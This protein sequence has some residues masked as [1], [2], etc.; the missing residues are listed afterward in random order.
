MTEPIQGL[1]PNDLNASVSNISQQGTGV[2]A[3]TRLATGNPHLVTNP[4]LLQALAN[5]NATYDQ[6]S[7]INA[8]MS[9]L[10][11]QTAV[12]HARATGARIQMTDDETSILDN[13]KVNYSDVQQTPQQLQQQYV[14]M[15]KAKGLTLATDAN[16]QIMYGSDGT[17][18]INPNPPK[19]KSGGGGFWHN[20]G[21][22]FSYVA[23]PFNV[24]SSTLGDAISG[25]E[26]LSTDLG[27]NQSPTAQVHEAQQGGPNFSAIPEDL[28]AIAGASPAQN[29]AMRDAGYDPSNPFSIIA[30]RAA[31][32]DYQDTS[33]AAKNWDDTHSGPGQMSGADA[34]SLAQKY[35]ANPA[36]VTSSITTDST[37]TPDQK[38]AKLAQLSADDFQ[39]LVRKVASLR[40]GI[41]NAVLANSGIDPE[42]HPKLY[43]DLATGI[44]LGASFAV[45]PL[46]VMGK[47]AKEA[48]IASVGLQ[49]FR[50]SAFG[51]RIRDI[52]LT[53]STIGYRANVQRGMQRFI[54][55]ANA[56]RSVTEAG[57]EATAEGAKKIAGAYADI[58]ATTP[59]LEPLV[60]DFLGTTRVA[61]D[62]AGR[63][64][65]D[66]AGKVIV[67]KGAPIASMQE[68][69]D[70]LSSKLA[71]ARLMNGR[72]AVEW[73]LMPGALSA[74][75]ARALVKAP[76]AKLVGTGAAISVG[77]AQQA[78]RVLP[79]ANDAVD[80]SNKVVAATGNVTRAQAVLDRALNLHNAYNTDETAQAV[81]DATGVVDQAKAGLASARR[82]AEQEVLTSPKLTGETRA[83]LLRRGTVDGEGF[84]LGGYLAAHAEQAARRLTSFL[85]RNLDISLTDASSTD[86][87]YKFLQL[88]TSRGDAALGAAKWAAADA[89]TRRQMIVGIQQQVMHSAGFGASEAGRAELDRVSRLMD[90]PESAVTDSTSGHRYALNN[91]DIFDDPNLGGLAA[92]YGILPSHVET[93]WTLPSFAQLAKN[94]AQSVIWRRT[95]GPM[96]QSKIADLMTFGFKTL[97][98]MK[99]STWTRNMVEGL[100]NAAFRGELGA[101]LRAK[102]AA[103]DAGALPERGV[104][105]LINPKNWNGKIA[106]KVQFAPLAKVGQA[107]RHIALR[108]AGLEDGIEY[109]G[110]LSKEELTDWI[111]NFSSQHL[112]ADLD[113]GGALQSRGIINDGLTPSQFS[114][115]AQHE[116]SPFRSG[117]PSY[118]RAGYTPETADGMV[119]ADRWAGSLATLVNEFPEHAKELIKAARLDNGDVS[120]VINAIKSDP[121]LA[122]R[123]AHLRASSLYQDD[124]YG[125]TFEA[126]TD[127]EREKALEQ[128]A[129]RQVSHVKDLVTSQAG[130]HLDAIENYVN[131]YNH[132]PSASWL[133]DNIPD[134]ER[135]VSVLAP[136]YVARPPV[137]GIDGFAAALAQKSDKWYARLVEDP[138]QH[139]TSLPVFLANYGKARYFLSD[140]E[141]RL[142]ESIAEGRKAALDTSKMSAEDKMLA[143]KEI[144][145]QA[146]ATADALMKQQAVK[147]S[148]VRT[149]QIID[150]PGLKTQFD[151]VG[152]N[153]FMYSRATQ[154]MIRRWGQA[155]MQDPS[156]LEKAAL[157]LHAAEHTGMVYTDKNG[158]LSFIYPGSGALINGITRLSG[159]FPGFGSFSQL[160]VT[161][162]LTGKVIFAAPGLDNPFKMALSPIVNIPYRMI[163]AYM[164]AATKLH[165]DEFDRFVNGPVGAGQIGSQFMPAGLRNLFATLNPSDRK[166]QWA[167]SMVSGLSNLIAAD[168][169]GTKGIVPGP[170][171]S[172]ADKD[173]FLAR[174][175]TQTKNA[176]YV[177]WALGL[178]TP[179]PASLPTDATSGSKA[180]PAFAAQGFKSLRDEYQ[181]ILNDVSGDYAQANQIWASLHPDKLVY[182]TALSRSNAKG[183]SLP[184]DDATFKWMVQ[185]SDFTNKYKASAAYFLPDSQGTFSNQAYQEEL[186]LGMRQRFTPDEFYQQ[187]RVNQG[188]A[189]YWPSWD[190]YQARL[191]ELKAA[192][193]KAGATALTA[194]WA[195]WSADF[196]A[197]NPLFTASLDASASTKG[198][199]AA[200]V[201]S[202][203]RE[204]VANP[205]GLPSTVDV[206]ALG[207]MISAYDSYEQW[208]LEN[209][210][211]GAAGTAKRNAVT[212]GYQQ[213]M[214][215]LATS[216]PS[217]MRL[218]NGVFRP[219]SPE[220]ADLTVN[221]GG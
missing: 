33:P 87:V 183:V 210:G 173:A 5:G 83:N 43:N 76:L 35:L 176:L 21:H 69:A 11:L 32:K 220:L 48:K 81:A 114:L 155:I 215:Q 147:M 162:D 53:P 184:A 153:F 29:Q 113:P 51:S 128:L 60:G 117:R 152:R 6:A 17:P 42:T 64:L 120:G 214:T 38:A 45:D 105:R 159:A 63:P 52:L 90:N 68:A 185:N 10:K 34:V 141:A 13:M 16:G 109:I 203:L 193:D 28:N 77:N 106:D 189:T 118:E 139:T 177:R 30:Y 2:D 148:W 195:L 66:A 59:G 55:N 24:V 15:A 65:V 4:G 7:A 23:K 12:E 110:R 186:A 57:A 93:T 112:R 196:K 202:N 82:A 97:Q 103:I 104:S 99:P 84:N 154:A 70:Y 180:D 140:A 151:T 116:M 158:Q 127:A 208:R 213:Y 74:F 56:I 80:D 206:S 168:P 67:G 170:N 85:P 61:V 37:L 20:V 142:A 217:L 102:A 19:K 145:E 26:K 135:P 167:S 75:G 149:E 150:D 161:P 50:D 163:E 86:K 71:F 95:F 3:L 219:L 72:A 194:K 58:R 25:L 124:E 174:W 207:A 187:V 94:A 197:A 165:M 126:K 9:G 179:A 121:E 212:A 157:L 146:A 54:D 199:A 107:Y 41:G 111:H 62:S 79:W 134:A 18:L 169:D 192:G 156:R 39:N 46:L 164:P 47:A 129:R 175:K 96:F 171:A 216:D 221:N 144:D 178:F 172:A 91:Q 181:A 123:I 132:A 27:L 190:A 218:Y 160:P 40:S 125:Q 191:N 198:N 92:H 136:K 209:R 188:G 98:L 131:K 31:G 73:N 130:D 166:S 108:N 36:D 88:Y 138:I 201:L 14:A 22:I 101:V 78:M 211:G 133:M 122:D 8:F 44:D 115:N 100:G 143:H 204:M 200:D 49:G 137:G 119:G 205:K 1:L 182:E 89:G